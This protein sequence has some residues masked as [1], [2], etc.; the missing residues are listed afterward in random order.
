MAASPDGVTW[1]EFPFPDGMLDVSEPAFGGTTPGP[2]TVWVRWQDD[3]G[4]WS[5]PFVS[6][7][8]YGMTAPADTDLPTVSGIRAVGVVPGSQASAGGRVPIRTSWTGTDGTTFVRTYDY[9]VNSDVDPPTAEATGHDVATPGADVYLPT[10]RR[11]RLTIR[12]I[13][14][15]GNVGPFAFGPYFRTTRYDE[16]SSAITYRGTWA[17]RDELDLLARQ[18]EGVVL[19]RR[20]GHA[21]RGRALHRPGLGPR[22]DARRRDDLRQRRE[23]RDDRPVLGHHAAAGDR[24]VT[25]LGDVRAP[26][27]RGADQWGPQAGHASTST[28]SSPSRRRDPRNAA[29]T[30]AWHRSAMKAQER[31]V[32]ALS[33]RLKLEGDRVPLWVIPQHPVKTPDPVEVKVKAPLN[34]G[35]VG[36][37]VAVFDYDRERDRIISPAIPTDR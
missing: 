22:P 35:P 33:E 26:D 36:S 20:H 6:T 15:T 9:S 7:V 4:N 1:T 24:V 21:G 27:G 13:D 29:L 32:S 12:A 19:A 2:R 16:L 37:N 3:S 10:G 11:H 8:W 23:G 31:Q 17:T 14:A 34:A 30:V 28:A 25:G 18:G 5:V